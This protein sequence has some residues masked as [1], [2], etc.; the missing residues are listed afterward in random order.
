MWLLVGPSG[1]EV[2]RDSDEVGVGSNTIDV[3]SKSKEVESGKGTSLHKKR[4]LTTI[5]CQHSAN[6]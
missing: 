3:V 2:G 5:T 4:W 6:T 1:S